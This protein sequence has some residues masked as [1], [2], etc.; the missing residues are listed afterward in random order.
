VRECCLCGKSGEGKKI[1]RHHVVP[2]SL[3]GIDDEE[4]IIYLCP[5]CHSI[6][7][8][9]YQEQAMRKMLFEDEKFFDDCIELARQRIKPIEYMR[10]AMNKA[11]KVPQ[12]ERA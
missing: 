11:F 7:H 2:E 5:K 1:H 3:G 9:T 8:W 10:E 6:L 12:K 4:N